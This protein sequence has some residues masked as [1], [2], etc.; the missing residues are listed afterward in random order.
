M[1]LRTTLL[2]ASAQLDTFSVGVAAARSLQEGGEA[3][4]L[5]QPGEMH[6]W[7]ATHHGTWDCKVEGAMGES[8]ATWASE[9]GPGGLWNLGRFRGDMMGMPF[10]GHE[11]LGYDPGSETFTSVWVDSWTTAPMILEGSYDATA[12]RLVMRGEMPG[13]DGTPVPAKHV[14]SYPDDDTMVFSMH[15]PG[16]DGPESELMKITYTR[17][18]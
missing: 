5:P 17:R 13:P 16:P 9:A 18:E 10:E 14:T 1:H 8:T 2:S 7:L 12:R 11:V 15:G 3:M 6:R 4:A